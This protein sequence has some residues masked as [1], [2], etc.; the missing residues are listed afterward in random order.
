MMCVRA[1]SASVPK[2]PFG[3]SWLTNSAIGARNSAPSVRITDRS[4]K[5]CSSRILPGQ[6]YLTRVTIY[7]TD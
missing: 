1:A 5:F 3:V 4:I 7:L 2:T 6:S